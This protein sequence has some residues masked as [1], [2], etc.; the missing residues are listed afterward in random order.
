MQG[1]AHILAGE[2]FSSSG[3][4]QRAT[5]RS[6]NEHPVPS[7]PP[8]SPAR[9]VS[10]PWPSGRARSRPRPRGRRPS[11]SFPR[12]RGRTRQLGGM[13][14]LPVLG[15]TGPRVRRRRGSLA[16]SRGGGSG[17]RATGHYWTREFPCGARRSVS[18]VKARGG[19]EFGE[20]KKKTRPDRSR[21]GHLAPFDL[22]LI[23]QTN[24]GG[25]VLG[26]IFSTY[27]YSS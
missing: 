18:V 15:R 8:R 11:L 17:K 12:A 6:G 10:R 16:P 21:L 27:L 25:K 19:T 13:R 7:H 9:D 23:I 14:T 22:E 3:S 5:T 4:P 20:G 2:Y 1:V 24:S 26:N